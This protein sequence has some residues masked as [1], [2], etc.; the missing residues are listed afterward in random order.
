MARVKMGKPMGNRECGWVRARLPLW[1][2]PEVASAQSPVIGEGRDLSAKDSAAIVQHLAE[3]AI[4]RQQHLGLERA[5]G[6]SRWLRLIC[7][8][9]PKPRR[10]GRRSSTKLPIV[11]HPIE[12]VDHT[13]GRGRRWVDSALVRARRGSSYSPGMDP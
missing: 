3:C 4:C 13:R 6:R 11:T 12:R 7:R 1:V 2:D 5:L 8:S 10:S 9:F